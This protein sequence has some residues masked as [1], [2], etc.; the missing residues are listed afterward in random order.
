MCQAASLFSL[1]CDRLQLSGDSLISAQSATSNGGNITINADD[2]FLVAF[3][4]SGNN[5]GND[6]VADAQGGTGGNITIRTQGVLGLEEGRASDNN[7]SNDIDASGQTNGVV[8]II[9]P[10]VDAIQGAAELPTNTV[11]PDTSVAQVCSAD[12]IAQ[13][14]SLTVNGKGGIPPEPSEPLSSDLVLT[15]NP[16]AKQPV[17]P[18]ATSI[19]NIFP[20]RGVIVHEDGTFDLVAYATDESQRNL[21]HQTSCG[22]QATVNNYN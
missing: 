1:K 10:D 14:S 8:E 12:K 16:Q 6:I 4:S 5:E 11:E 2:G 15:Q 22:K 3:P 18:V 17:R 20:A 9:T 13:G 19:G 21:D 7:G